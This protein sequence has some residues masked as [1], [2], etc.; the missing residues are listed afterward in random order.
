[1]FNTKPVG[2][3]SRGSPQLITIC[4]ATVICIFSCWLPRSKVNGDADRKIAS[5]LGKFFPPMHISLCLC[6]TPLVTYAHLHTFSHLATA[7]PSPN[8]LVPHLSTTY[9]LFVPCPTWLSL[10]CLL[11]CLQAS[12]DLQLPAGS[13]T[14]F[15]CWK[16]A[17]SCKDILD[18][19]PTAM[20]PAGV[21][22]QCD[23]MALSF[24][25]AW[26][27]NRNSGQV[28]IITQNL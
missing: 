7:T 1:M 13:P 17:G 24:M 5:G 26:L 4:S 20:G 19:W 21:A 18:E 6:H 9:A 3:S 15:G 28:A 27:S 12:R 16:A 8:V 25:T 22:K 2:L 11:A 10:T 23:Y 14:D